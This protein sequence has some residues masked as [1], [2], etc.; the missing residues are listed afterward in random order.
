M[1]NKCEKS[2]ISYVIFLGILRLNLVLRNLNMRWKAT[3]EGRRIYMIR[4]SPNP[5]GRPKAI[6]NPKVPQQRCR[7]KAKAKGKRK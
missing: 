5:K 2:S 3:V 6:R 1:N 7:T 4:K